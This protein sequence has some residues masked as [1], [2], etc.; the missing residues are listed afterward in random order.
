LPVLI[1]MEIWRVFS[2]TTRHSKCVGK[3]FGWVVII[4][5][6]DILGPLESKGWSLWGLGLRYRT[7]SRANCAVCVDVKCA[8]VFTRLLDQNWKSLF[9]PYLYLAPLFPLRLSLELHFY[10]NLSIL[11]R[12]FFPGLKSSGRLFSGNGWGAKNT[13]SLVCIEHLL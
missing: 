1:G 8:M 5:I 3:R 4:L 11:T 12:R 10:P 13:C 9:L 6:Q 2:D 7:E